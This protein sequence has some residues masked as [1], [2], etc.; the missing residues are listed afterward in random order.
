MWRDGLSHV[1]ASSGLIV[2]CYAGDRL[3]IGEDG[4]LSVSSRAHSSKTGAGTDARVSKHGFFRSAS[5]EARTR[6]RFCH[7]LPRCR[8]GRPRSLAGCGAG[9][10][11]GGLVGAGCD[12][13][14]PVGVVRAVTNGPWGRGVR[15][16]SVDRRSLPRAAGRFGVVPVRGRAHR[17]WGLRPRLGERFELCGASP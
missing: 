14:G 15:V 5:A 3:V 13:A 17:G 7:R 8:G 4:F 1:D 9:I 6:R 16:V 10:C 12:Q 11:R 2:K